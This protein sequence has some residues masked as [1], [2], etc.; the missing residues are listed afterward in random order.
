MA[1]DWLPPTEA[2][3]VLFNMKA[4]IDVEYS[5]NYSNSLHPDFT[6]VQSFGNVEEA[7]PGYFDDWGA[8]RELAA[9]DRLFNQ[10][11]SLRVEWNFDP[12]EDL[13]ESGYEAIAELTNY[14]LFV[15]RPPGSEVVY[16]GYAK[17]VMKYDIESKQ[18]Q[19]YRWDES[20]NGSYQSWGRLRADL[21]IP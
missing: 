11:I 3:N 6:F 2:E 15:T 8:E 9:L 17:L 4:G 16:E 19:L 18:W 7:A 20:E 10:A 13:T 14:Q 5:T 21:Q 12:N 1:V